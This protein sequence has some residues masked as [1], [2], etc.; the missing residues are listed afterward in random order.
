MEWNSFVR[1]SWAIIG[2]INPGWFP[3]EGETRAPKRKPTGRTCKLQ[4]IV[5]FP[6]LNPGKRKPMSHCALN[7]SYQRK[8]EDGHMTRDILELVHSFSH[9]QLSTKALASSNRESGRSAV[10]QS[11]ML[12]KCFSLPMNVDWSHR[13]ASMS[14]ELRAIASVKIQVQINASKSLAACVRSAGRHSAAAVR[15]WG[16]GEE[17]H[18]YRTIRELVYS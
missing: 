12:K 17:R 13:G 5:P 8:L 4:T 11:V 2:S 6:G 18:Y 15:S 3:I 1:V 7:V 14:N 16:K 10:R 9:L